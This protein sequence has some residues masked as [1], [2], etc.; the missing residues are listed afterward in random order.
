MPCLQTARVAAPLDPLLQKMALGT[1][2]FAAHMLAH[3][4]NSNLNLAEQ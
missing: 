4:P 3:A 2:I 1:R